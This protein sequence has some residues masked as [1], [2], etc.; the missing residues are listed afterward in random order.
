MA[1]CWCVVQVT[2]AVLRKYSIHQVDAETGATAMTWFVVRDRKKGVASTASEEA[3]VSKA[4]QVGP[5]D[6]LMH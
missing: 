3:A 6:A 5:R 4:C 1:C 2:Q